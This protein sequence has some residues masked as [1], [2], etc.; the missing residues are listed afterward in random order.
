[1]TQTDLELQRQFERL[2]SPL[3]EWVSQLMER[4]RVILAAKE[5]GAAVEVRLSLRYDGT[6]PAPRVKVF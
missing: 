4:E 6:I 2:D 3:R 1:M 5:E